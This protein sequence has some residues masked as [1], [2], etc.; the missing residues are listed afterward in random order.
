MDFKSVNRN[1]IFNRFRANAAL[2]VKNY[3][4]STPCPV[5]AQIVQLR[6]SLMHFHET[7]LHPLTARRLERGELTKTLIPCDSFKQRWHFQGP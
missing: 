2:I 6:M 7:H 4:D 5:R 3:R 1:A